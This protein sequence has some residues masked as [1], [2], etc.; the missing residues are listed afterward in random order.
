MSKYEK[1]EES[2]RGV[3]GLFLV[4]G[5]LVFILLA[6]IFFF[7]FKDDLKLPG[8][9]NF[10]K[11]Q[12]TEA[13]VTEQQGSTLTYQTNANLDINSLIIE[14]YTALAICDQK[15]LQNIV[16]DPTQFDDMSPYEKIALKITNYTNINCY[17]LPGV[18]ENGTVCYA[19]CN[20]SIKDVSSAPLNISRFYI[21]K[22]ADGSYKID[23]TS[24]SGELASYLDGTCDANA[25]IQ[26]LYKSVNDN[27][28]AC[29]DGDASFAS[30]YNEYISGQ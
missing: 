7:Y 12:V 24:P 29:V 17:T 27:I 6:L 9:L 28:K 14:Y 3:A 4:F 16:T 13:E 11:E 20:L 21:V 1:D 15:K 26:A 25:D 8:F 10:G 30:F 2:T 5:W 18:D 19:T 22:Q 23:N